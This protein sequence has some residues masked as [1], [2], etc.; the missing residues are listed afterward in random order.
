MGAARKVA[1]HVL[2]LAAAQ[3]TLEMRGE[4][5]AGLLAGPKQGRTTKSMPTWMRRTFSPI[6]INTISNQEVADILELS[7]AV[8][9]SRIHGGARRSA[10]LVC[11]E[12]ESR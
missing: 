3:S 10:G 6:H 8:A 9:K 2:G 5:I 4:T 7:L 11:S 12:R 1:Q